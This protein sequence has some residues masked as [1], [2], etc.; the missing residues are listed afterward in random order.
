MMFLY[1]AKWWCGLSWLVLVSSYAVRR[2]LLCTGTVLGDGPCRRVSVFIK[3]CNTHV[4]KPRNSHS[5]HP[6][7]NLAN[8]LVISHGNYMLGHVLS[9]GAFV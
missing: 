5:F 1:L 2:T 4:T 8:P 9:R 3:F 7:T 6:S